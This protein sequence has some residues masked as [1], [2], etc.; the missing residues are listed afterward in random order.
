MRYPCLILDH[1]DTVVNSTD[2][3]HYPAFVEILK[4][5]RPQLHYD[6]ETYLLRNFDPGL[7]PFY[8]DEIG[9]SDQEIDEE[10]LFWK[11]YVRT[12]VPKA[13]PGIREILAHHRENGGIFAVVSHNASDV[14][15]RD[16]RENNLPLPD[17]IF[18]WDDLP[19][20]RKPH[21][22]PVEQV[23]RKF[24][25]RPDQVLVVDDLKPGYDMARAA[26]VRF[27]AALWAH[28]IPEINAFMEKNCDYSF[29]SV[30]ALKKF[31]ESEEET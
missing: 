29:H 23:M 15:E 12:R 5:I 25:F 30:E 7:L 21:P 1:D 26:G 17:R 18:G 31:L 22:W 4:L 19:E 20:Q 9:L 27:A 8:H 28:D 10:W 6:L 13:Y 14:I 3:I 24:G 2:T 16:Y 11:E